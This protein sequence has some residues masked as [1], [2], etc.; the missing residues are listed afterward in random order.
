MEYIQLCYIEMCCGTRGAHI[1][2]QPTPIVCPPF[3]SLYPCPLLGFIHIQH[4]CIT[5]N[6]NESYRR[7][8][9]NIFGK[10]RN[11]QFWVCLS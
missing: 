1:G 11:T 2:P 8:K 9:E 10:T 6:I 7:K 5:K 4:L 3:M